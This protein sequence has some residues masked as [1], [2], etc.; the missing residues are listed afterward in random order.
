MPETPEPPRTP[1]CELLSEH[2]DERMSVNRFIEWL[3]ER[4]IVLCQREPD[5]RREFDFVPAAKNADRL[6]MDYIGIDQV[7]LENERRA[8]LDWQRELN[9]EVGH[10]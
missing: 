1:Q 3:E 2:Y 5:L 4:G 7:E 6:F 10:G 9:K 8:L